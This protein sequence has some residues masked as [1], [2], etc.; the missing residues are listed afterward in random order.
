[1]FERE[2]K[3]LQIIV[4]IPVY[5]YARTLRD[6]VKRTLEI[7]DK[8]MV[9]DD[10]CTDGS[11][12]TL[13]SLNVYIVRH[14]KNRGKGAAVLTAAREA[15][16]LGMTHI[17][18]LDADGQHDP[19]DFVKFVSIM[20]E[21][22][23]AIVVGKR[24]FQ[25]AEVPTSRR[26]GRS[27]SNFWFRTQTGQVLGDTHSGYRAYPLIILEKLKLY[28]RRFSFEIEVLVKA[29]WAGVT[30]REVDISVHYPPADKYT[31]H[32]HLFMDNVRLTLLNTRLI[33]RSIIPFPHRKIVTDE[34]TGETI[35]VLRPFQS[36]KDLLKESAA[37]NQIAAAGALGVF[38][39]TL[40]LIATHTVAILFAA[41]YLRLNRAVAV[42]TS[43]LCMP[44]L[45]PALCIETGY[46]MRHGELLTEISLTT[47]GYQALE[48]CFEWVIGSL[49]LAPLF[50]A[51]VGAILYCMA[52]A[53]KWNK[54]EEIQKD[55]TER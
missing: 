18:T 37:P 19:R 46:F 38:L 41:G 13:A 4:V 33:F 11:I 17:V 8:V 32:F 7:H 43:Q 45:V 24:D 1:M 55:E 30:I 49:V 51:L 14:E 6:V 23:S 20:R 42:S 16:R 39:G 29:A 48:R 5:N 27:F 22:P 47:L 12:E 52:V 50:A 54:S 34:K 25:S 2:H 53:V 44:P 36:F 40:P 21:N 35:T 9:V 28:E 26:F 10:G 31:S 15:R 3:N